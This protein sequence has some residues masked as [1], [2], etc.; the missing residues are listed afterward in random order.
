MTNYVALLRGINVGGKNPVPM[1]ELQRLFVGLGF[2]DAATYI[3]SGNVVFSGRPVEAAEVESA[4]EA[5]FGFAVPVVLRTHEDIGATV[6]A[7]PFV[8]R[9][10]DP[11]K[12]HVMYLSAAPVAAAATRLDPLRSPPDEFAV[13]GREVFLYLPNGMGRTKLTVDYVE[14]VLGVRATARN[15]NTTLKLHDLSTPA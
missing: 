5:R 11:A 1:V 2:L 13:I 6:A 7:N 15:W 8:S 10:D 3:Q 12:L 9:T 4:I 14:R